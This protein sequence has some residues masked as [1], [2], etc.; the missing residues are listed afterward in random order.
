MDRDQISKQDLLIDQGH[1]MPNK[2]HKDLIKSQSVSMPEYKDTGQ[3]FNGR[4]GAIH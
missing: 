1:Y 3:I 2:C 4:D